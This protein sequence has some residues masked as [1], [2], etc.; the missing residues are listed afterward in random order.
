MKKIFT[1]ISIVFISSVSYAASFDCS[2]AS[3]FVEKAICEDTLMGK[4]DDILSENY[5]KIL[6]GNIGK[7]SVKDLKATQ[8]KWLS[9]RNKCTDN[10]CLTEAY[11]RRINE[12]CDYPLI[13]GVLV[14]NNICTDC[15]NE[16][17]EK[18]NRDGSS[19]RVLQRQCRKIETR[20]IRV[21]IK[22][23]QTEKYHT[24]LTHTQSDSYDGGSL[25]DLEKD[26]IFE[27]EEQGECDMR[28]NCD[29]AI[30]K[31]NKQRTNLYLF[32]RGV[33]AG[34]NYIPGMYVQFQPPNSDVYRAPQEGKSILDKDLLYHIEIVGW[35]YDEATSICFISKIIKGKLV[36]YNPKNKDILGLC[37]VYEGKYVVNPPE[38]E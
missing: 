9:E 31:I 13:P 1:F 10:E 21:Q 3:T 17:E 15:V 20:T 29:T 26:E 25:P 27:Y 38:P 12:I 35:H 16:T 19:I 33:G 18:H 8:R 11:R 32:Y 5:N 28:G 37:E 14:A 24:V 22:S 34:F 7:E 6:A 23:S 30:Y 36:R 4:L 2:K